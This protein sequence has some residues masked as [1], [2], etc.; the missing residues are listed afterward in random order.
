MAHFRDKYKCMLVTMPHFAG[1]VRAKELGADPNG[2]TFLQ[3]AD[4]LAAAVKANSDKPVVLVIH[5]WG[6]FWGFFLQAKYPEL[7]KAVVAL[8]VGY[9]DI[10]LGSYKQAPATIA[11]GIAYQYWNML[12]FFMGRILPFGIGP[13]VGDTMSSVFS[14]TRF[15][16]NHMP[17][18]QYEMAYPYHHVHKTFWSEQ[19]GLVDN[20]HE[21]MSNKFDLMERPSCPCLFMYGTKKPVLFHDSNWAQRLRERPDCEVVKIPASHWLQV[22]APDDVNAHMD[23]WLQK[24]VS[25][26]IPEVTTRMQ[27]SL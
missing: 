3:G 15:R 22:Q 10:L 2:Y 8:D 24:L 17:P 4:I 26:E 25:G 27:S 12:A 7:V 6:C 21:R 14:R 9:P 1:R 23:S 5:D 13:V 20:E 19:L 11:S 16:Y 18:L